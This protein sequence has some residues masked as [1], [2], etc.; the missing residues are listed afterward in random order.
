[1]LNLLDLNNGE[2]GTIVD[3]SNLD[4]RFLEIGFIPNNDV[5]IVTNKSNY[6][7]YVKLNDS[8][9]WIMDKKE[10]ELIKVIK[11]S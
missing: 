6:I 1:M 9:Y 2:T 10:A 8:D 3:S 4:I 7:L 5:T 11:K